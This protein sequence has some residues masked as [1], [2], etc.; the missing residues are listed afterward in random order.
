MQF[1]LNDGCDRCV[2]PMANTLGVRDLQHANICKKIS[3]DARLYANMC[4]A[5]VGFRR[6]S[7]VMPKLLPGFTTTIQGVP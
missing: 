1:I 2:Y 6:K 5:M 4:A 7:P 3:S